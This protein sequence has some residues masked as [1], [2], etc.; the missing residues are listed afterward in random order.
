MK[1]LLHII[2]ILILFCPLAA[3]AQSDFNIR[4]ISYEQGLPNNYVESITQD[5]RGYLWFATDEGL[6]RYDG[7]R[8]VNYLHNVPG[9]LT[10]SG[11]GL[12]YVL[13]DPQLPVLWIATQSAGINSYNYETN[14]FKVYR[15]DS[16]D[17]ESL[18]ADG[19]TF[20]SSANDGNLWIG[21]YNGGI[22]Y[23]N[24]RS[25]KF[26]HY[27]SHTLEKGF[28]DN[29]WCCMEGKNNLLY[30][31]HENG[32]MT[33][34]N[35]KTKTFTNYR[36]QSGNP[37]SIPGNTVRSI[38][39]DSRGQIW[40]ATGKGAAVFNPA[41]KTFRR[42]NAAG[43]AIIQNCYDVRQINDHEVWVAPEFGGAVAINIFNF[44]TRPL[45]TMYAQGLYNNWQNLSDQSLRCIFKDTYG[46]IWFGSWGH[47]VFMMPHTSPLFH[48]YLFS[49]IPSDYFLTNPSV[50]SVVEDS[51]GSLW[52]GTD[53]GGINVFRGNKRT[54]IYKQYHPGKED[55]CVQTAFRDSKGNLWFGLYNAGLLVFASGNRH[56]GSQVYPPAQQTADV[57]TIYEDSTSSMLWVGTSTGIDLFERDTHRFSRHIDLPN[58]LIRTIT[59]D[60]KGH[61][62]IGTFNGGIFILTPQG[63][64]LK[65]L[66]SAHGFRF[67][68]INQLFIDSRGTIW[69]GTSDG[70][71]RFRQDDISWKYTLYNQRNGLDNTYIRAITED[72]RQRLWISTNQ[73][74]CNLGTDGKFLCYN[75]VEGH[76]FGNFTD[77]STCK[78]SKG[79]LYFGSVNGLF[80]FNPDKLLRH[81]QLPP[82][83]ISGLTVFRSTRQDQQSEED[84]FISDGKT[85]RLPHDENTFTITFNTKDIAFTNGV[86]YLYKLE[87]Q[88]N[89]WYQSNGTHDVTYRNLPP[90]TYTFKVK[91]CARNETSFSPESQLTIHIAP[92]FYASW[93]A[94]TLYVLVI[95]A[96]IWW[97][98]RI[99]KNRIH[100]EYLYASERKHHQQEQE[101]NKERLQFYTNITHELRTP[102]TLIIGPIEDVEKSPTLSGNDRHT[103]SV[104]RKNAT[105]LL[106]LVNELLEF[107]KTETGN[108][109]LRVVKGDIIRTIR[110]TGLKYLELLKNPDVKFVVD[111]PEHAVEM[112]YDPEVI[113]IILDNLI[114]NASKYTRQGSITL[115][116]G[117]MPDGQI[118]ICVTDT[119]YGISTQALPHIFDRYYQEKSSHQASGTGIG[120]A[121]VSNLVKLHHGHI[122][123]TSE[124]GK[125]SSFSLTLSLSDNYPDAIHAPSIP[126]TAAITTPAH[127]IP[128]ESHD[129]AIQKEKEERPIVLVVEDN[130]D[131]RNYITDTLSKDFL[132]K[133]AEN[134]KQGKAL[135]LEITPDIIISDILMPE[136]DGYEMCKELKTNVR[137]SHI[138]VILL[139]AKTAMEDKLEGYEAGADSYITKPFSAT[140][141]K[142]RIENIIVQRKALFRQINPLLKAGQ[143]AMQEKKAAVDTSL[144]KLDKEFLDKLDELINQNL[145]SDKLDINFL[146]GQFFMSSST[147]YRKV[148]SLTGISTKEY[149]NR[150][151]MQKAE[152]L[153]LE[154]RLSISEIADETGFDNVVYFRQCFKKEFGAAPSDYL[155][156]LKEKS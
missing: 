57:R 51:S 155:K 61:M 120:L 40:L 133:T 111:L 137:T 125:G 17:P 74:I 7:V 81:Q 113:T 27:N 136:M 42:I 94:K 132:I 115:S 95:A 107:R 127:D 126:L 124:E 3:T 152:Q 47:G 54:D 128:T 63:R 5:K 67:S 119:G 104:I 10:P 83:M 77:R 87:G 151:R 140:L 121:L 53:G 139:T 138:P 109:Q 11:K 117:T 16:K 26:I 116:A 35:L 20:L 143:K 34:L 93:W 55:N 14:S 99:Y 101:L 71:L 43:N 6:S 98:L 92:P 44:Q 19:I 28:C 21:T 29:V 85:A 122:A 18:T 62:W 60:R 100:L 49:A 154:R 38:C 37:N 149:I 8:F 58:N 33:V 110:E 78:D 129:T 80:S 106:G 146:S 65:V 4:Q 70:L 89:S 156:T 56:T 148:K 13:D 131:I 59:K 84:C 46:N 68:T 102:L 15:H 24:K 147:L 69:A 112:Y 144:N 23:F 134:G 75:S 72:N 108:R 32:G 1:T 150:K 39:M 41:T 79:M 118:K 86:T 97:L 64:L 130:P 90:G 45:Q 123:V 105:R 135:A 153:L 2:N 30:I 12:N 103:I 48:H 50:M 91:A 141:L 73:S 82:V 142:S 96:A 88:D 9:L 66:D 114:S 25:G 52:L 22:N 36:F 76:P 31:G 145:K